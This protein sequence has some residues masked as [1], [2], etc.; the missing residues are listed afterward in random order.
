MEE[1]EG[2]VFAL[3]Q[4]E[5]VRRVHLELSAACLRD[6][7]KVM[8]ND[9]PM[10]RMLVIRSQTEIQTR[11]D[12]VT[13]PDKLRA[14]LL[15]HLDLSSVALTIKSVLLNNADGIAVLAIENF[16]ACADFHP[17]HLVTQISAMSHLEVLSIHF[18]S[19][20]PN[21]EVE[22]KL[23]GARMTRITLP[24]LR[25]LYFRG[26]SAYLEGILARLSAPYL[27]TLHVEFFNQ[28]TFSLPSLLQFSNAMSIL[29]LNATQV[30]FEQ[31]FVSLII[32]PRDKR[33]GPD[34]FVV[35]VRC[36]PL[37]WQA[38]CVT[39]I[40]NTLAPLLSR[41]ESLKLGF[42]T[43][44]RATPWRVDVNPAERHGPIRVATFHGEKTVLLSGEFVVDLFRLLRLPVCANCKSTTTPLW[45][46]D[47]ESNILCNACGQSCFL[48]TFFTRVW[49]SHSVT[50]LTHMSS[51]HQATLVARTI[52]RHYGTEI[53][54]STGLFA[55]T[56]ILSTGVCQH[57]CSS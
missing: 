11:S 50:N 52:S 3:Q 16:P 19:A 15:H 33:E 14:P 39:Q 36:K 41:T 13:L 32:D 29:K 17:E 2:V 49:D 48:L 44:G 35:Q 38:S 20:I 8:D 21:R 28:L 24:S 40:C 27:Q 56:N 53:K 10:L 12:A 55:Y 37:D 18:C 25:L 42:H 7:V 9:Y 57:G 5:R 1:K 47:P 4:R 43:D 26:S 34:P 30:Y 54:R 51:A 22:R 45:R 6:L 46:S 23:L 31:D